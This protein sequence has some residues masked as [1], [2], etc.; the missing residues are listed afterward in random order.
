MRKTLLLAVFFALWLAAGCKSD[1]KPD[2]PATAAKPA[3]A[4]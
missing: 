1:S 3:D 4:P 2:E